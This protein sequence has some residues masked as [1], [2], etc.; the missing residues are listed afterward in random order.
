MGRE[1]D[2]RF[3]SPEQSQTHPVAGLAV[4]GNCRIRWVRECL[5]TLVVLSLAAAA[6]IYL[7]Y[8]LGL[9]T[10]PGDTG[11]LETT[12]ALSVRYQIENGP[13]SL[14]GP[15]TSRNPLVLIHAPLYYRLGALLAWSQTKMGW[16]PLAAAMASG[17]LISASGTMI[18]LLLVYRLGRLGGANRWAGALAVMLLAAAPIP[19]I[20]SVMVRPDTLAVAF[21]T[22]GV[23]LVLRTIQSGRGG[24]AEPAA[25][26][27]FFAL[28][29]CTKQHGL[30]CPAI[31]SILLA[32]AWYRG[33]LRLSSVVLAHLA[34]ILV[35]AAC[36]AF[37]QWIT[38]GMMLRSA[39]V[40][41]AGPF[42][43]L[44]YGGWVHVGSVFAIIFKKMIGF[45]LLAVACAGTSKSWRLAG[46]ID[47]ILSV[48]FLAE[49]GDLVPLCLFN[50]GAADNYALQAVLLGCVLVGRSLSLTFQVNNAA[51][52]K[53]GLIATAAAALLIRDLQFVELSARTRKQGQSRL[54]L[55]L[56]DPHLNGS[57]PESIY[58]VD[59]PQLNRR[60]G[61]LGL[62][63]D[64][65]LYG[66]YEAV[67]EAEPRSQWLRRSLEHGI[68]EHVIAPDGRPTIPGLVQPL[69]E[70]GF[71]PVAQHERFTLWERVPG[72]L[73]PVSVQRH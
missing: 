39:F 47:A 6:A 65:W 55:L 10:D 7:G 28:A 31:S 27:A 63:H 49:V 62:A 67:G 25:A 17:R 2:E 3:V 11:R 60:F 20:L 22:F 43:T 9:L 41:P 40:L 15:F 12:L 29:I 34:G 58:F 66:A 59:E 50:L 8:H 45:V 52:W 36:I 72:D 54:E 69:S 14:Y 48:Y 19:G 68:V 71:S 56:A 70:L 24:G 37:E 73:R 21:Q 4:N 35:I 26:Y 33:R 23:L 64:E 44:N 18:C 1:H 30:I 5:H 32:S 51:P 46:R 57:R 42:R 16:D 61:A 53:L 38:G 13:G